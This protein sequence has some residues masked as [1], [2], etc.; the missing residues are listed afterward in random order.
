MVGSARFEDT[1][2]EVLRAACVAVDDD[3]LH[4]SIGRRDVGEGAGAELLGCV[5]YR[6]EYDL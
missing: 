4:A 6:L 2:H 5:S 3:D 1:S